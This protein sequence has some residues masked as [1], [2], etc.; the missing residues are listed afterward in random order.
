MYITMVYTEAVRRAVLNYRRKNKETINEKVR[1]QVRR[2][3]AKWKSY[4]DETKRMCKI[5]V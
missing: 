3:R 1:E 5:E 2:H 4:L